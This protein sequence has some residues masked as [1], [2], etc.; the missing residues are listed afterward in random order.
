METPSTHHY[1]VAIGT[2]AEGVA[3]LETFFDQLLPDG[4]SYVIVQHLSKNDQSRLAQ[5]ISK[6]SK[7][8]ICE[9]EQG[10]LVEVNKV[11]VIPHNKYITIRQGALQL[12]NKLKT[13]APHFTIDTFFKSLAA[14][15]GNKAIGV[16]LAGIGTDGTIG[17]KSI[18]KAGGVVLVQD[19]LTAKDTAMPESAIATGLAEGVLAISAMPKAIETYVVNNTLSNMHVLS[20]QEDGQE[21]GA[22]RMD[23][24]ML[25]AMFNLIK[26]QTSYDFSGYKRSTLKRR[27]GRRITT[28]HTKNL[29]AYFMC[30][31][32][33]RDEVAILAQDLLIYSTAFFRDQ[34]EFDYLQSTIIPALVDQHP[35]EAILKIW[36]AGCASGEE[37]YS[38]A[39]LIRE[40]LDKTNR[41]L[42]V[43]LFATDINQ[44]QISFA[45]KG[46]YAE[47][48]VTNVSQ[49]R[50]SH[51]FIKENDTYQVKPELRKMLVFATH[52]LASNPP[53]CHMD[54]IS[55][56]NVLIYMTPVLQ[57]KIL[58]VLHFG[59][60]QE[61]YLFLGSRENATLAGCSFSQVSKKW[62]VYQKIGP[63]PEKHPFTFSAPVVEDCKVLSLPD[64]KGF[65]PLPTKSSFTEDM[66]EIVMHASGYAGV[67]VD[68]H[69][70]I[71]Q[72][73]GDLSPYLL[74]KVLNFNLTQ[75][76]PHSLAR[77]FGAAVHRAIK[78]NEQ[79]KFKR[80]QIKEGNTLLVNVLIEP[81]IV[82]K[83]FQ[84][85]ILVLFSEDQPGEKNGEQPSVFDYSLHTS[86][87]M[88]DME[89]ELREARES[90]QMVFE[91]S[92]SVDENKQSIHEELLAAN[93]ELQSVNEE[94]Q[95]MNREHGQKINELT[96]LNDDFSNYFRSNVNRQL[97][98]NKDLLI[99]KF[100]P[101]V[102]TLINL[103]QTDLG[104]PI[105]DITIHLK[106]QN[107]VA[108]L[109]QVIAT[110]EILVR[111]LQDMHGSWYQVS[112]MPYIRQIGS[113]QD[114]AIITF[115]DITKL[116]LAQQALNLSNENLRRI[117]ADLD[118][119]VYAASHDLLG[120]LST[121][122]SLIS[123]VSTHLADGEVKLTQY[124]SLLEASIIKFK[125]VI[126]EM[127][128]VGRTES[129]LLEEQTSINLKEL[130]AEVKLSIRTTIAAS[131]ATI[132]ENLEVEAI[133][134]SRKSLRSIL[135]NLI[136]NALKFA[137]DG[138]RP[139]IVVST[140]LM[141]GFV[142]L[143]VS[144]N[145]IG[146]DEDDIAL[147]FTKYQRL[148]TRIEG[149]G[150]GLYLVKK[151]VDA[152]G[153]KMEITS[154]KGLGTMFAILFNDNL[155]HDIQ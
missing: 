37:A 10:M 25:E 101:A 38:L 82:R 129:Q 144:D 133:K 40:Y 8:A 92:L 6:H 53:Y 4:I 126:Q 24:A 20:N 86:E 99:K 46:V 90:L 65:N 30:L 54:L 71:I 22:E 51:F 100:S 81:F 17:I 26:R 28:T 149:Q 76:L 39:M 29:E 91:K 114:G 16:I 137:S 31:K 105:R 140:K 141:A 3:A 59:L 72:S 32:K 69:L 35:A 83:N 111:E 23:E 118:N 113:E 89:A 88:A 19:P 120:P 147:I 74:P 50:L 98:V 119:F 2:S 68:K 123:L 60:K 146:M 45:S 135:Y 1:I 36:C 145:G 108:D 155:S 78:H 127:A 47:S 70:Q 48:A 130:L 27:I 42:E 132:K 122:E 43:K 125:A 136:S 153:G 66:Y 73:F 52:D 85:L 151:I 93:E 95:N 9:A 75:L 62:R 128:S 139:E 148:N 14:E 152:T 87:Y 5:I 61:G 104:R 102:F 110:G 150:L 55:C 44:Q 143:T 80:I 131:E 57:K 138:R 34:E 124:T 112:T 103:K 64:H 134:F 63:F 67:C 79:V 117:N 13:V 33:N 7:L 11:Y 154:K 41:H 12:T 96:E 107:I 97:Y 142:Q 18:H 106:S 116:K 15:R 77:V 84:K 49:E 21:V 109:Q 121:I 58:S 94:L 56:R 115:H